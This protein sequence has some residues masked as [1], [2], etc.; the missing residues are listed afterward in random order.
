MGSHP[1]RL[2]F[3]TPGSGKNMYEK[4]PCY[5][6]ANSQVKNYARPEIALYTPSG[7]YRFR[8]AVKSSWVSTGIPNRQPSATSGFKRPMLTISR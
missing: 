7:M 4:A 2:A 6:S 8:I 3:F 1:L 5:H